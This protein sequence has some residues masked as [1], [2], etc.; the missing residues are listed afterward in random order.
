MTGEYQ[1]TLDSKG[2]LF[3]PA[4]L[5]DELGDV[6]YLTVSD[7]RCLAGVQLGELAGLCGQGSC[8]VFCGQEEDA[9]VFRLCGE[10]WS[11]TRRAGRWCRRD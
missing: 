6:F 4:K 5:R 8:D 7:E 3:I 11:W 10:V 2:R 9:P 1:H